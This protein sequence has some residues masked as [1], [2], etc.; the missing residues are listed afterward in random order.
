MFF[1]FQAQD[2]R[3]PGPAIGLAITW[4]FHFI[5]LQQ[6]VRDDLRQVNGNENE[7]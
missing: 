4:R 7:D 3:S 6:A 1:G 5:I 2:M